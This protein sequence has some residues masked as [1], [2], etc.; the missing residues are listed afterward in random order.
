MWR[1]VRVT[2]LHPMNMTLGSKDSSSLNVLQKIF[3][4]LVFVDRDVAQ[5]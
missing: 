4:L 5:A 1:T 2:M 3:G